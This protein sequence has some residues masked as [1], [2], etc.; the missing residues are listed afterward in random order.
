MKV[1]LSLPER[2]SALYLLAVLD[3]LV[4]LLLFFALVPVVGQQAG[5]PLRRM[6][7]ESLLD[8]VPPAKRVAVFG[9]SG[10]QARFWLGHRRIEFAELEPELMRLK[11]ERGIEV[12]VVI[13]DEDM[14]YGWTGKF[15]KLAYAVGV[16]LSLGGR[17]DME[18]AG[19]Q[20][21]SDPPPKAEVVEED[22][23]PAE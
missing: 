1:E 12:M 9:R 2:P 17:L 18:R 11:E 3:I 15:E 5:I 7:S 23:S 8:R 20:Q 6:E 21:T 10:P 19:L 13:L 22:V 4:V 16:D 14:D